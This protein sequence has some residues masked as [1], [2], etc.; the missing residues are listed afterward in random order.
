MVPE[1]ATGFRSVRGVPGRRFPSS[2]VPEPGGRRRRERSRPYRAL[3]NQAIVNGRPIPGAFRRGWPAVFDQPTGW[4]NRLERAHKV[5]RAGCDRGCCRLIAGSRTGRDFPV[6][7]RS[8]RRP[9]RSRQSYTGPRRNA[10]PWG[11]RRTRSLRS[12]DC[13]TGSSGFSAVVTTVCQAVAS[14]PSEQPTVTTFMRDCRS[15]DAGTTRDAGN[16]RPGRIRISPT[17]SVKS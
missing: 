8:C 1:A 7:P 9:R 11:R 6:A 2:S 16:W 17:S 3:R 13:P 4:P 10:L 15:H 5:T 12:S 14:R